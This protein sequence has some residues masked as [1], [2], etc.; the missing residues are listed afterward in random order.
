MHGN[1]C[2]GVWC[3]ELLFK[4]KKN[5]CLTVV[6]HA[7]YLNYRDVNKNMTN[8]IPFCMQ[9]SAYVIVSMFLFNFCKH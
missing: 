5:V 9:N 6:E 4:K 1:V 2:V 3:L 7:C 8:K